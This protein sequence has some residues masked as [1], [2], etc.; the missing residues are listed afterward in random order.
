MNNM[1]EKSVTQA[2]CE[3]YEQAKPQKNALLVVGCSTSEVMGKHIGS[4]G[5]TEV[6]ERLYKAIM[7]FCKKHSL[8]LAVQCCEHLNRS[9]VIEKEYM[10]LKNLNRVNAVPALH[11]GGALATHTFKE[12]NNPV[13]VENIQADLGIDIGLTLIGMHLKP[14][15][16]PVRTSITKIG[17]A[18][19][20]CARTR[21]KYIG[22]CRAEYDKE[23]S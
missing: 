18:P 4:D 16:I 8:Y 3:L 2:L 1:I 22:G 13:L 15:A 6:A 17:E 5:N 14:I 21:Y 12:F 11:A 9:L 10:D 7:V 20:V 23:L 19:I